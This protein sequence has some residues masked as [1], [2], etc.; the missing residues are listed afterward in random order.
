MSAGTNGYDTGRTQWLE[1]WEAIRKRPGMYIGSTREAGLHQMVFEVA[2]RAVNEVLAGRADS[3]EISLGRDGRLCVADDG[4]GVPTEAGTGGMS[5]TGVE[6][7]LTRRHSGSGGRNTVSLFAMGPC[8]ATALSS[9]LTA[10]ARFGGLRWVHE[11]ARGLAIAPPMVV[12]PAARSGMSISFLPD[13]DIFGTAA[14]SF[15]VLTARFRELAYLNRGLE[16]T[17]TDARSTGP[18]RATFRFPGGARDFVAVLGPGADAP[19]HQDVIGFE[20]E[21]PRMAG[22]MEVALR[23]SAAARERIRSFANSRPTP[24]GGTHEEGFRRAVAAALST[25]ARRHRLL[26]AAEPDLH[27][28]RTGQGMTAVVSV[29]LDR[30]EYQGATHG[31]L[32]NRAAHLCVR[33]AVQDHLLTW[34]DKHPQQAEAIVARVTHGLCPR[35]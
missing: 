6:A 22:T 27:P 16:I 24:Q 7:M 28:A 35:P 11:Y 8:V 25:Y 32:G 1:G 17:M 30:P 18:A 20:R 9:R 19:V 2:G 13:A 4:P 21:D 3:V 33:E 5:G 31:M 10:E 34:L 23:W 15:D 29:K 14:V 26:T 12:G